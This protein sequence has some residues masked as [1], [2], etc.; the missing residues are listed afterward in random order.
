MNW[1]RTPDGREFI[2]GANEGLTV[3][4]SCAP[5][6]RPVNL[7]NALEAYVVEVTGKKFG[8]PFPLVLDI[9]RPENCEA[10]KAAGVN[11]A[12]SEH[13][14]YNKGNVAFVMLE[15]GGAGLRIFDLRDGEHPKEVAYYN[16]RKGFAHSGVFS[17]DET[18]GILVTSGRASMHVLMMQPQIIEALG[19]PKP[20]DPKYPYK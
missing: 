2:I 16:D 5:Y 15:Y 13:S 7:G 6:P 19:L 9:N 1:W 10:A 11:A 4:N 18:R 14:I 17:Y 12:I 8:T 20:T 3:A